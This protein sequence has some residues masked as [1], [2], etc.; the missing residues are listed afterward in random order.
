MARNRSKSAKDS[1]TEPIVGHVGV[2]PGQF[3][4]SCGLGTSAL[5]RGFARDF[6]KEIL[7]LN[8]I[9]ITQTQQSRSEMLIFV[10]VYKQLFFSVHR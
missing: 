3:E 5:S 9:W 7:T 4:S 8:Q 10:L 6:R 1:T 2:K